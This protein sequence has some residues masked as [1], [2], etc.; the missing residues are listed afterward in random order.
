MSHNGFPQHIDQRGRG[1]WKVLRADGIVEV[2]DGR[3]C[4]VHRVK[5]WRK[6]NEDRPSPEIEM[7]RIEAAYLRVSPIYRPV[8]DAMR[9]R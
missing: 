1:R 4:P 3:Q 2:Q 8:I 6:P 9:G 5:A 7:Q